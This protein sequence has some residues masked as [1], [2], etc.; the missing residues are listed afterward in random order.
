MPG[1]AR[2]KHVPERTCVG[3]GQT[4]PKRQMVRVIRTLEGRVEVDPTGKKSGRGA[5]LCKKGDCWDRAIQRGALSR[6]LKIEL[7]PE[8]REEL[9]RHGRQYGG[10]LVAQSAP[11]AEGEASG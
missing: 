8:D 3:C 11:E 6:A 10:E 4:Q 1:P 2:Q 5:Y 7:L 9:L